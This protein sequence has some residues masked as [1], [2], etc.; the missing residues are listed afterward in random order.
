MNLRK[1]HNRIRLYRLLFFFLVR[2]Y[3]KEGYINKNT[4]LYIKREQKYKRV[5][6]TEKRRRE[7]AEEETDEIACDRQ[8]TGT[9]LIEQGLK[10][11]A[12]A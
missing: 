8:C 1:D 5:K 2:E 9:G 4:V 6:G 7:R 10:Q 11:S 3:K 12:L